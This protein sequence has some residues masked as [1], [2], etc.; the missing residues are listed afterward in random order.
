MHELLGWT[1]LLI[2]DHLGDP[3]PELLKGD[4]EDFMGANNQVSEIGRII[5]AL[6]A[7]I[8]EDEIIKYRTGDAGKKEMSKLLTT[9]HEP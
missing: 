5:E 9:D 4:F 7:G 3:D 1:R 2:R 8:P 6:A